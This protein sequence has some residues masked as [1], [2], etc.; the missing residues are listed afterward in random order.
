MKIQVGDLFKAKESVLIH[1]CNCF[2]VMG[3]GVA[4][5]VK[6]L[7]PGAYFQADLYTKS[8]D[9]SKL[10]TYSAWTGRH[11]F[12]E[13]LI[14]IVNAYTQYETW[15]MNGDYSVSPID[16][17]ALERVMISIKNDFK[18]QS[19]AMPKIGAGLAGGDWN[20][21]ME[22]LTR[23]FEGKEDVTVYLLE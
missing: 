3:A 5:Q 10:G 9:K 15:G 18:D 16:Y 20:K 2:N 13:Q 4:S 11:C 21:I 7:Y 1:G 8:G 17:D 14:T 22:I 6:K 12:Y 19:I 23:V